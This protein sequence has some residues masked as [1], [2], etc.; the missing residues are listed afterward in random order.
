MDEQRFVIHRGVDGEN[1]A[2]LA[3]R[4]RL[5]QHPGV[6]VEVERATGRLLQFLW[7]EGGVVGYRIGVRGW[8]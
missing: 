4:Y 2:G 8:V 7:I 6:E 1:G 3:G 5:F